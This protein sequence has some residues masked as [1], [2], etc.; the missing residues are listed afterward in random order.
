MFL[1]WTRETGVVPA[2]LVGVLAA[3]GIPNHAVFASVVTIAIVG[4][5]LLQAM[6]ARLLADRLGLL[7]R[8]PP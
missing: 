3:R 7:D 6:P 5:L 1:C 8:I 2:A 4:T